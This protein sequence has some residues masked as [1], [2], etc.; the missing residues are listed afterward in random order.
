VAHGK[1]DMALK[2]A[3]TIYLTVV[4][5][6]RNCCSLIQSNYFGFG[7]MVVPADVGFAMQNRGTIRGSI[8]IIPT[9]SSPTSGRS[10]QSSRRW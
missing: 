7:S 2:A 3:D 4:D 6:D 9:G 10:T 5:K 8:P 1:I